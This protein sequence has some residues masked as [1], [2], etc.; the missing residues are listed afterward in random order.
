M[1]IKNKYDLRLKKREL[2]IEVKFYE[3]EMI[4][5]ASGMLDNFAGKL[6]NL[7]FEFGYHLAAKYF[8]SRRRRKKSHQE[9]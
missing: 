3:K 5:S 1:I 7:A 6:K 2:E 8:F 9:Y 4:A